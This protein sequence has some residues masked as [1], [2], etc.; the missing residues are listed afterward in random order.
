MKL[1]S[2]GVGNL[3]AQTALVAADLAGQ[4]VEVVFKDKTAA[5]EKEFKALNLTG[6]FPLLQVGNDTIFE[7]S[8]I[9]Q[10]FAR[11][12]P[13]SGLLGQ[14]AFETARVQQ[15]IDQQS[16]TVG[17]AL[18]PLAYSALGHKIVSQEEFSKQLKCLQAQARIYNASLEGKS[19][20]VGDNLTVADVV[21][22]GGWIIAFQTVFDPAFRAQVPH[23]ADW[24]ERCVGLPSFR[25][26]L[27]NIKMT[28]RAMKAF[29][30][31]AK[32]EEVVAAPVAAAPAKEDD[33][34]LDLFGDDD[35]DAAEA[36]AAAKAAAA[37]AKKPKKKVTAM[38]L[39]MLEVKPLDDTTNLDDIAKDLFANIQQDGLFW[40]TE[41]KKEPVAFGI[42]KLIVGFSL[43]DE[44]VSVDDIVEK[45]EAMEDKV[46]SVEISAFNK[47]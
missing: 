20:L 23:F 26:R 45:I 15:W 4:E 3:W 5:N 16:A 43:E 42:F 25:R 19:W 17:P 30:P 33:D 9:A 7:S 2:N 35:E 29:D 37:K 34:D 1:Y 38:S 36:V 21:C 12:A 18:L 10:Y 40:K 39:V 11:L 46:Q 31:N 14:N 6:K 13:S 27:G 28:E 8:A 41:Y 47:I 32:P 22:A 24:F 44:K